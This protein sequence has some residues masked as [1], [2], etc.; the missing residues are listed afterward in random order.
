[1][2]KCLVIGGQLILACTASILK[3]EQAVSIEW[4]SVLLKT[5]DQGILLPSTNPT[6]SAKEWDCAKPRNWYSQIVQS[7]ASPNPG[8]ANAVTEM[9]INRVE[10]RKRTKAGLAAW[11]WGS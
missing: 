9:R 2:L 7:N 5:I 10:C 3:N 4:I 6:R 1:M 8:L 11:R